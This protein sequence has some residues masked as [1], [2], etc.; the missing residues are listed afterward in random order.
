MIVCHC[1]RISDKA[2]KASIRAGKRTLEQIGDHCG[3]GSE[4]GGC[5]PAIVALIQEEICAKLKDPMKQE[6]PKACQE[7]GSYTPRY[8]HID[9]P[10]GNLIVVLTCSRRCGWEWSITLPP[11]PL[12][13]V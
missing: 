12:I 3:A 7:C 5:V 6:F 1:E 11:E 9:L 8:E 4:C 13:T 10:D 2:I